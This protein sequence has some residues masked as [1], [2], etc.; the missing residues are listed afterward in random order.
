[1]VRCTI[2]DLPIN[3]SS[4]TRIFAGTDPLPIELSGGSFIDMLDYQ[5]TNVYRL[6]CPDPA[7]DTANLWADPGFE[8]VQLSAPGVVLSDWQ[9]RRTTFTDDRVRLD[10]DTAAPHSGRHSGVLHM[11]AP[12]LEAPGLPGVEPNLLVSPALNNSLTASCTSFHGSVYARSSPPGAHL[13]LVVDLNKTVAAVVLYSLLTT[14]VTG[15]ALD[16]Y[17]YKVVRS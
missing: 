10:I 16:T 12:P 17:E 8:R 11:A 4:A 9:V 6:G 13:P 5:A 14:V 2:T 1:M 3:I 7:S 15:R